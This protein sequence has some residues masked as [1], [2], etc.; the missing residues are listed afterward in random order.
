[1]S[2][3]YCTVIPEGYQ[4]S[5]EYPD[6]IARFADRLLLLTAMTEERRL[7]GHYINYSRLTGESEFGSRWSSVFRHAR[8]T[9]L[10][11]VNDKYSVGRF[12][13]SMCLRKPY[14]TGR[15]VLYELSRRPRS[16]KRLREEC[17]G[18]VG[19][20]LRK[21]MREFEVRDTASSDPWDMHAVARLKRG[22]LYATFCDFGRFHT[23]FTSLSKRV[24]A[25]LRARSGESLCMVDVTNCQPL[26]IGAMARAAVDSEDVRRW[27]NDC[28]RGVIYE[29]IL[30]V[31]SSG[32]V[33]SSFRP[34]TRGDIKKPFLI[35]M[36]SKVESMRKNPVFAAIARK[37]PVIANYLTE[38]KAGGH[39][40]LARA[41]Q[42]AESTAVIQ[43]ACARL[44]RIGV[45]LLTVHDELIVPESLACQAASEMKS[46]FRETLKVNPL[47]NTTHT[48]TH[49]IAH[50]TEHHLLSICATLNAV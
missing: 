5:G 30:D 45:P 41:C 26:I 46:A 3:S 21:C 14:R 44:M 50:H 48:T 32:D 47:L 36:F 19:G 2:D 1:M 9:G 23:N 28:E 4:P 40:E 6:Q 7:W 13:K 42:R 25:G 31:F 15:F 43:T 17:L 11:D 20:W 27:V 10:V 35:A 16:K 49:T 39:Q 8:E 34:E 24:R 37:Y 22:D 33:R 38:A 12:S 18:E 29:E